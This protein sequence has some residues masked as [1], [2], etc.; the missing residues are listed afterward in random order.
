MHTWKKYIRVAG[1][2]L[3][4]LIVLAGLFEFAVRILYP[5]IRLQGIDKTL[6]ADNVYGK[7]P[8]LKPNVMGEAMGR[9]VSTN[10]WGFRSTG[11]KPDTARKS[12]LL[13]GDSVTFGMGVE[14]DSTFPAILQRHH[15]DYNLLNAS[16][17]GYA[18]NDYENI[19]NHFIRE[20]KHKI[21]E[22]FLFY[23]LNDLYNKSETEPML[24]K[25]PFVGKLFQFLK[26]HSYFYIW[27]KGVFFDRPEAYFRY[28][29][30]FY[31][32]SSAAFRRTVNT[33]KRIEQS[34]KEAG[35]K[36]TL[37]LLPYEF[38]LRENEKRS[39][40]LPQQK[41][42][43]QLK[44]KPVN[45]L[46]PSVFLMEKLEEPA[47]AYLFADG[48]HFSKKGHRLIATYL[49]K[50]FTTSEEKMYFGGHENVFE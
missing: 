45:I 1:V 26:T 42:R 19:V 17:A 8:G 44:N 2:N 13:L 5:K 12:K 30:Q 32:D 23:C 24:S 25:N 6:L 3:I 48:I 38:Q 22:V 28:D 39:G 31:K 16:F 29:V 4:V 37:V 11:Q 27:L 41:L 14:D 20:K 7:T 40:D 49:I 46:D 47:S 34:C 9:K 35:W 18:V 33:L 15:R 50:S 21:E 36:Y 43:N 10:D